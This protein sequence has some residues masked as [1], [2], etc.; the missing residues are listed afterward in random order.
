MVAGSASRREAITRAGSREASRSPCPRLSLHHHRCSIE[1]D[2]RVKIDPASPGLRRQLEREPLGLGRVLPRWWDQSGH[3]ITA[4][5]TV[6]PTTV[7]AVNEPA[8]GTSARW[9]AGCHGAL[10]RRTH[11]DTQRGYG[12]A[13]AQKR[14]PVEVRQQLRDAIYSGQALQSVL[15]DLGLTSN[16]VWGVTRTDQEW[17]KG[18][19]GRLDGNPP[20]RPRTR[21]QR[22]PSGGLRLP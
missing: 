21:H 14:L 6:M 7:R 5:R 4:R 20:R 18:V 12:R 11:S 10:C 8:H 13:R 3:Q 19:G 16:Q 22:R 1:T 9:H 15:R 2:F 17:S